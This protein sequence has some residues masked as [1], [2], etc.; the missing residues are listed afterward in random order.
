MR[1]GGFTLAEVLIVI[2][3]IGMLAALSIPSFERSVER[4]RVKDAQVTLQ[5]IFQAERIFLLD[6]GTS[7]GTLTP[8][9]PSYTGT[10]VANN[11]LPA[12]SGNDWTYSAVISPPGTIPTFQATATRVQP[13]G[14][15][16][17]RLIQLDQLFTN[18][19]NP[20]YGGRVFAGDH[21]LRD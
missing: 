18:A 17:G 16:N 2:V 5:M 12:P 15:Y 21:P 20:A 11:Y 10:L 6:Q 1:R 3:I 7:Y 14:Q 9:P 19:P 4:A 13:G 8:P